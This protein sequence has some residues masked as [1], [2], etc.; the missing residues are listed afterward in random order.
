MIIPM[1]DNY[2]LPARLLY[3]EQPADSRTKGLLPFSSRR[4]RVQLAPAQLPIIMTFDEEGHITSST[5][6][7]VSITESAAIM[8]RSYAGEPERCGRP[9]GR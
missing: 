7:P 9:A 5:T 8:K 1:I 4:R 2:F 3:D 6:I